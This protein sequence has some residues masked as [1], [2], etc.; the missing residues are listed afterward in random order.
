MSGILPQ[1]L[2]VPGDTRVS[3]LDSPHPERE[4]GSFKACHAKSTSLYFCM[5][6]THFNVSQ[7]RPAP[8]ISSRI[9]PQ[10]RTVAQRQTPSLSQQHYCCK[11]NTNL[12][13]QNISPFVLGSRSSSTKTTPGATYPSCKLNILL[14]NRNTLRVNSA[15]IR[16]LEKM[17][18]KCL[19]SFL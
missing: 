10:R 17:D 3:F 8:D 4:L 16:I 18:Q 19:R 14:H 6:S 15:Q 9:A 13:A 5:S 7:S 11:Q 2:C 1:A 12:P